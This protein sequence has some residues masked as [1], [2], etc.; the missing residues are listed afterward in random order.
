MKWRATVI[1]DFETETL[2]DAGERERTIRDVL[3]QHLEPEFK[4]AVSYTVTD[5]RERGPDR[6]KERTTPVVSRRARA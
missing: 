2:M 6:V 5:R 1:I 3:A 4:G